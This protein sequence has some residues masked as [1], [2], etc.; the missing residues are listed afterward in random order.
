M[1]IIKLQPIKES[2]SD[3]EDVER[4]IIELLRKE[5]YA[6]IMKELGA[7]QS[8][9]TNSKD[10][11]LKAIGNGRINFYRG[12]FSGQFSS[13]VSQELKRLGAKWDRKTGTFKI[14][15]SDLPMDVRQTISASI[16]R[17]NEKLADIDQKLA[18]LLPEEIA[19]KL[20]VSNNF[21]TALWKVE[22]DFQASIKN[23]TVGPNLTKE[24][25]Q[26]IADR[27]EN[28]MELWVKNFAEKQIK[29]LR[30]DVQKA[31]FS[32]KRYEG[33]IKSLQ[34]SY[35]VSL[36]KAKFLARQETSLLMTEF[37][38][39]RYVDANINEYE[40]RCVAGS[41]N[42]PV[43]PSHKILE[44][45]IFRWD[46]PPITT[47]PDEPQRKNNPGQDYNCRCFAKPIVRFK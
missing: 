10:D 23:I 41:K 44:G 31:V 20:N 2:T 6:P 12:S 30:A 5:L 25:A 34:K 47:A 29:E 1:K 39:T 22:K 32:G 24:Q 18:K 35:G 4:K 26:K 45:K 15:A 46:D 16:N 17:I 38:Q 33:M 27:W 19:G 21:S 37:K 13:R 9:L 36:N 40:W 8:K 7:P 14:P 42:H 11:L 28:N 3:Y 43:R